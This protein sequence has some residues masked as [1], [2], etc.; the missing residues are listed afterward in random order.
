MKI[1]S[2]TVSFFLAISC[3]LAQ[4]TYIDDF[5]DYNVGQG[6]GEQSSNWLAENGG[7]RRNFDVPVANNRALS[8]DKSIYFERPTGWGAF[9]RVNL[10]VGGASNLGVLDYQMN[11]YIAS[12][13]AGNFDVLSTSNTEDV[14]LRFGTD[15]YGNYTIYNDDGEVATGTHK[16]DS[17]IK[18]N[19]NI[20]LTNNKWKMFIDDQQVASFSNESL[21]SLYSLFFT[22]LNYFNTQRAAFWLDDIS[23]KFTDY[24]FK[25][26]NAQV[27]QASYTG[28]EFVGFDI[29]LKTVIRNL[30]SNE[31]NKLKIGFIYNDSL[32]IEQIE[33]LSLFTGSVYEYEFMNSFKAIKGVNYVE[34]LI[35]EVDGKNDEV[36]SDNSLSIKIRPVSPASNKMV[37]VEAGTSTSC[38]FCPSVDV[39]M[40]LLESSLGAYVIPIEIHQN[41]IME[42]AG[43]DEFFTNLVTELPHAYADR[44]TSIETDGKT[45]TTQILKSLERQPSAKMNVAALLSE[46]KS[47]LKVQVK[48]SFLKELENDGYKVSCVLVEDDFVGGNIE[49]NQRNDYWTGAYGEMGGYENLPRIIRGDQMVYRNVVREYQPSFAG[50][51]IEK[52]DIIIG[53]SLFYEFN[54]SIESNWSLN[55]I[56]LIPLFI[57]TD[58]SVNNAFKLSL[59]EALSND[60]V[61]GNGTSLNEIKNNSGFNVYPNPSNGITN[62]VFNTEIQNGLVRVVDLN[63]NEVF[64]SE[65]SFYPNQNM[66]IDLS[67]QAKGI[68]IISLETTSRIQRK[69]YVK[70]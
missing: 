18:I 44:V 1:L 3:L 39:S 26:L 69:V 7:P 62:L 52:K 51:E 56:S 2:L 60:F 5:E 70:R 34:V 35:L 23:F 38:P 47:T 17:W 27:Y 48:Y 50:A 12:G 66:L 45:V 28:G 16:E 22:P 4:T 31:I 59:N 65:V 13:N 54:F 37:L 21:N 30:G 67:D 14:A 68:Y 10:L 64:T 33:G 36:A 29:K 32:T 15:G 41:D 20:D 11:M 19:L 25:D 55:N 63:G 53:D 24:D 57:A 58:G 9:R 40:Q 61:D 49:Y 8:G 43:V 42:P 6:I 46:D